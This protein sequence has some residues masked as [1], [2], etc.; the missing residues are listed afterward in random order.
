M[1]EDAC[2]SIVYTRDS[3]AFRKSRRKFYFPF[4]FVSRASDEILHDFSCF[5]ECVP[6]QALYFQ[7][8][9]S[10]RG[11]TIKMSSRSLCC[12]RRKMKSFIHWMERQVS[13]E[14]S[15]V[16]VRDSLASQKLFFSWKGGDGEFEQERKFVYKEETLYRHKYLISCQCK[17]ESW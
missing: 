14:A 5:F 1:T 2:I 3:R 11:M 7:R 17:L 13:F 12:R 6:R 8:K 15:T 16:P 10:R 9:M 4:F